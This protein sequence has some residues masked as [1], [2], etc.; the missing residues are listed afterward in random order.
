MINSVEQKVRELMAGD[1]TGHSFDHVER[2]YKTAIDLCAKE[3]ANMEVVA[4]S[5]LLHDADD[6]KLFGQ[7]CADKLTNAKRIMNECNVDSEVQQ[8]VCLVIANMGYSKALKGIRPQTIEGKIVSD[9]DMLDAIGANGIVRCMAFALARCET[10]IFNAEIWP[11]PDMCAEEYKRPNRKSDNFIN[12][13]FEKLLKLKNMMMTDAGKK[14]AE[15]RHKLM[16]SFLEAFFLENSL[17][18]WVAYLYDYEMKI[19]K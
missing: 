1:N 15:K 5:A 13:F 14:E 6:Y 18:Q 19:E 4:I 17:P 10:P 11:E 7:E 16:V 8:Q 2:V 9:A 3:D 12:H